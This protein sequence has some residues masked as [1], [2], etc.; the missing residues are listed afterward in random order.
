MAVGIK[1][2]TAAGDDW[3]ALL[4]LFVCQRGKPRMIH[5]LIPVKLLQD[6]PRENRE[7][8][9]NEKEAGPLYLLD[10]RVRPHR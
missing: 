10:S 6:E 5:D 1:Q 4:V 8:E 7:R 9:P 2:C 3:T